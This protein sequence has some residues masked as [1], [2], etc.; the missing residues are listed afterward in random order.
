MKMNPLSN[1]AWDVVR[2]RD[3][4][5]LSTASAKATRGAT[6]IRCG[7]QFWDRPKLGG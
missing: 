3:V 1:V 7:G 5:L 2:E 6:S 4:M